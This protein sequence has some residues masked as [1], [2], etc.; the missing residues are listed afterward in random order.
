MSWK[1]TPAMAG[2]RCIVDKV[3]ITAND[4]SHYSIKVC[5]CALV[6]TCVYVCVCVCARVCVCVRDHMPGVH[7]YMRACECTRV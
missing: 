6:C 1:S 2:E 7:A 3:Q 4:E 5:A